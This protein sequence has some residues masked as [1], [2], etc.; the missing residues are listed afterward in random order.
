MILY[1]LKSCRIKLIDLQPYNI[2]E[3]RNKLLSKSRSLATRNRYVSF[4]NT[5]MQ[6]CVEEWFWLETNPVQAIRRMKEI[7]S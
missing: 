7:N 5:V 6:A 1:L 3:G 4:I 2:V